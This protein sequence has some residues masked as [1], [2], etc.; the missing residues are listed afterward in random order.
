MWPQRS[1]DTAP[2]CS[3]RSMRLGSWPAR[4]RTCVSVPLATS[5]GQDLAPLR[6]TPADEL[7][8][9]RL[10]VLRALGQRTHEQQLLAGFEAS[11]DGCRS[12][13]PG[14]R[15]AAA[16]MRLIQFITLG[17][18]TGPRVESP[19]QPSGQVVVGQRRLLGLGRPR[20]SR[21]GAAAVRAAPAIC[22]MSDLWPGAN[23]LGLAQNAT[24][25]TIA[26]H[27][28]PPAPAR[29]PSAAS[30]SSGATNTP[31]YRYT[32][33]GPASTPSRAEQ[34]RG[35]VST[36]SDPDRHRLRGAPPRPRPASARSRPAATPARSRQPGRRR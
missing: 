11:N 35:S 14:R 16:N 31:K 13:P 4:P 26:T 8:P 36:I 30:S 6:G 23:D 18:E 32:H 28:R 21:R 33:E 34:D 24:H 5:S 22:C 1:C 19:A 10:P 15:P 7:R 25:S 2:R 12:S 3:P 17:F 9:R 27:A 20:P 29:Q